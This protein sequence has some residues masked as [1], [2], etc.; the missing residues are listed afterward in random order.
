MFPL[1]VLLVT[2]PD[3]RW[4]PG[5]GDPTP[6]GWFTVFV[7]VV[8]T[9]TAA[10]AASHSRTIGSEGDASEERAP[11][12]AAF[13]ILV[14][15]A[16]LALGIN[17]QLDLQTWL[18]ETMRDLARAQGWYEGRRRVQLV[19]VVAIGLAGL[20]TT[21]GLGFALRRGLGR[22]RLALVGLGILATFIVVRAASFHHFDVLIVDG[23]L[24]LNPILELSGLA[25]IALGAHRFR[26]G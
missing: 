15:V 4:H 14:A 2:G 5:I 12:F 18:T 20:A 6:I 1:L 10:R 19:F 17:K 25:A 7:Y 3:G 13:W 8:A 26:R 21:A 9:I 23:P 24:P 16:T 11:A 22:I